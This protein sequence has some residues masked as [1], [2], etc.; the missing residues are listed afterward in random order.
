MDIL[1]RSGIGP[2]LFF[3]RNHKVLAFL[4]NCIS[5]RESTQSLSLSLVS[6]E[7]WKILEKAGRPASRVWAALT[8]SQPEWDLS[9]LTQLKTYVAAAKAAARA[10]CSISWCLY[11]CITLLSRDIWCRWEGG[12]ILSEMRWTFVEIRSA[13]GTKKV[14]LAFLNWVPSPFIS[15][16]ENESAK[17][18][19]WVQ[20]GNILEVLHLFC[21]RTKAVKGPA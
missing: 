16:R 1:E 14:H 10:L 9:Q 8:L 15:C 7:R 12:V 18:A 20:T 3:W 6:R 11:F 21:A 2:S 13:M 19:L 4:R 5:K 17:D